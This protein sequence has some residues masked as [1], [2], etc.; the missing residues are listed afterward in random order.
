MK[1]AVFFARKTP[2]LIFGEANVPRPYEY[3]T[4]KTP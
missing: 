2:L 1:K 4:D 3:A